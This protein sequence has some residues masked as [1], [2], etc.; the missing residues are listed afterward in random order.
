MK[1]WFSFFFG[2]EL[3]KSDPIDSLIKHITEFEEPNV[4]ERDLSINFKHVWV[5]HHHFSN[6]NFIPHHITILIFSNFVIKRRNKHYCTPFGIG[7]Y[8]D[9]SILISDISILCKLMELDLLFGIIYILDVLLYLFL[10]IPYII[11]QYEMNESMTHSCFCEDKLEL[12]VG[13]VWIELDKNFVNRICRKGILLL[14]W[15]TLI[16]ADHCWLI[17]IEFDWWWGSVIWHYWLVLIYVMT[18]MYR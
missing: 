5:Q 3:N 4:M 1:L 18:K 13:I 16:L 14:T 8:L 2:S 17:D 6:G 10:V 15:V 11:L 9:L 12:S 7:R